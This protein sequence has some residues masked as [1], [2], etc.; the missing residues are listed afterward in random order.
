[1][2]QQ[3]AIQ[4]LEKFASQNYQPERSVNGG[5]ASIPE[6]GELDQNLNYAAMIASGAVTLGMNREDVGPNGYRE[7]YNGFVPRPEV[8]RV[9]SNF[10]PFSPDPNVVNTDNKRREQAA[11]GPR[12]DGLPHP[13]KAYAPGFHPLDVGDVTSPTSLSSSHRLSPTSTRPPSAARYG[14]ADS[15]DP[16]A[17]INRAPGRAEAPISR[18]SSGQTASP[19]QEKGRL[20]LDPMRDLNHTLANLDLSANGASHSGQFHMAGNA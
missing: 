13:S 5:M 11:V 10:S 3:Q 2:T 9:L 6:G 8:Q 15:H 17:P 4:L 20:E 18:P 14:F 7:E 16:P 12:M 1:M 19:P